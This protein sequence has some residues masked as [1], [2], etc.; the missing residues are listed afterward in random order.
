M[1]AVRIRKD[2]FSSACYPCEL[3]T[4]NLPAGMKIC[5]TK[6]TNQIMWLI[7]IMEFKFLVPKSR[8]PTLIICASGVPAGGWGILL[9]PSLR[10]NTYL[11]FNYY[12]V[13]KFFVRLICGRDLRRPPSTAWSFFQHQITYPHQ[14]SYIQNLYFILFTLAATSH[15]WN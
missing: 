12:L 2:I 8:W 5:F 9:D 4:Q 1:G 14:M 11:I 13:I 3:G 6:Q 10:F 15:Y 7:A